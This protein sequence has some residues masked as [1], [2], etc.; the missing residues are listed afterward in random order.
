M[1]EQTSE[2]YYL[3]GGNTVGPIGA[4]EIR[5]ALRKERIDGD[6][7]VWRDGMK[8]WMPLRSV[9]ELGR[10]QY[11][12]PPPPR[13]STKP[14]E[15]SPLNVPLPIRKSGKY[16]YIAE[17]Y[18][19]PNSHCVCCGQPATKHFKRSFAFTPRGVW[20]AVIA[21][22][23]LLILFLCLRKERRLGFGLCEVH[24]KQTLIKNIVCYSCGILFIPVWFWAAVTTSSSGSMFLGWL[25]LIL[26]V[27]WVVF[28]N[29]GRP[30]KIVALE[31]GYIKI[32]GVSAS[33]IKILQ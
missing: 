32:S 31:N 2:W 7:M 5:D 23:I 21:P 15:D 19:L 9:E 3:S 28:C 11:I 1:S 12:P 33:L 8:D 26:F 29:V 14:S 22:F 25:G 6:V 10:V 13:V 27:T 20:I 30:I 4:P 18:S 24:A 16:L 17:G